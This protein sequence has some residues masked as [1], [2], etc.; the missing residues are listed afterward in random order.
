MTVRARRYSGA[1]SH[2]QSGL[3]QMLVRFSRHPLR[4]G[5]SLK[6][7]PSG[8]EKPNRAG[9]ISPRSALV[10]PARNISRAGGCPHPRTQGSIRF[11]KG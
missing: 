10:H 9:N 3:C 2:A 7:A 11:G 5:Q 8:Q 6:H 4:Q 1:G